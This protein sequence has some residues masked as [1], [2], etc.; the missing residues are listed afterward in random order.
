MPQQTKKIVL[1]I[2]D[3]DNDAE[4]TIETFKSHHIANDVVRL[5]DGEEALNYIYYRKNY[6]DREKETP[7]LILLDLKMPKIGGLEVLQELRDH[8]NTKHIPVVV[9]TSSNEEAD[10]MR[11]YKLG[12]NAYVVKPVDFQQLTT[13]VKELGMFWLMINSPPAQ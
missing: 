10:L 7:S 11:S 9:L 2:E 3:D 8:E 1:L 13:A 4:L 5:E 12:V 6:Q